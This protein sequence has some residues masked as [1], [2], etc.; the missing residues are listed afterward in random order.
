MLQ[1]LSAITIE[2]LAQI[3]LFKDLPA[4]IIAS[5]LNTAQKRT[6]GEGGSFFFQGDPAD[7]IYILL[8]GRVKLFQLTPDGQQVLLGVIAPWDLFDTAALAHGGYYP[9]TAQTIQKSTALYWLEPVLMGFIS[10]SPQLAKNALQIMAE[11]IQELQDRFRELATERVERRLAR[12][13]LRLVSQTGKRVP[14][15]VLLNLPIT[16][17]DLAEMTGTT[18]Y[19]VSRILSQWES[20]GLIQSGREKIIIRS[21]HNLVSIAEDLPARQT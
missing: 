13:I 21:P 8:E 19:T 18:L 15:G 3:P 2:N 7:K 17:Q 4:E 12:A 9:V 5:I 1:S 20:Q 6:V 14:E 16:R 11:H 10:K